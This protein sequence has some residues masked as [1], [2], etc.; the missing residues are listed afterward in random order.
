MGSVGSIAFS[1]DGTRLAT[2]GASFDDVARVWGDVRRLG[3]LATGPGRVKI[4]NLSTGELEHDLVGHSHATS[5]AF[6]SDGELL[7][8]SGRWGGNTDNGTGVIVWNAKS[9]EPVQRIST[10]T[11]MVDQVTF[12]PNSKS[13]A[14][15]TQNFGRSGPATNEIWMTFAKSGLLTWKRQTKGRSGRAAFTPDGR[16]FFTQSDNKAILMLDAKTGEKA[17]ELSIEAKTRSEGYR[18]MAITSGSRFLVTTVVSNG[19]VQI[20]VW[21]ISAEAP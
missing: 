21:D 17:F 2:A 16:Y 13:L 19:K 3:R 7:A 5:V 20:E 11:S 4:W 8:S 15:S 6:S 10:S 14:F 1:P 9:G 18:D 12:A